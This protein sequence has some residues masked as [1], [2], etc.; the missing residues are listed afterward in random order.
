LQVRGLIAG[1][2]SGLFDLLSAARPQDQAAPAGRDRPGL[3][4]NDI[5]DETASQCFLDV[6]RQQAYKRAGI[7][8]AMH[9]I[10]GSSGDTASRSPIMAP[11]S[12]IHSRR[13][14]VPAS[15]VTFYPSTPL[16]LAT[17]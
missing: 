10:K 13:P 1:R 7:D 17:P 9:H 11:R 12:I 15:S 8:K 14:T 2:R 4:G 5:Q 16:S 3:A 6:T